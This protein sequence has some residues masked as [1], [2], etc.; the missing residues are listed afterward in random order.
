MRNY[1]YEVNTTEAIQLIWKSASIV[2]KKGL[3]FQ[4]KRGLYMN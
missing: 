2:G 3:A 1:I 4:Q